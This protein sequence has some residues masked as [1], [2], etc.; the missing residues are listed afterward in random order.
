[1]EKK[2]KQSDKKRIDSR[3]DSGRCSINSWV[4]LSSCNFTDMIE[5]NEKDCQYE[6]YRQSE[7]YYEEL[8]K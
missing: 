6:S 3:R 5:D 7:D 2:S 1:M 4:L 8:N